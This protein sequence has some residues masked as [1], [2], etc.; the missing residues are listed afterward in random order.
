MSLNFLFE[1]MYKTC[2]FY[3]FK[4]KMICQNMCQKH[5]NILPCSNVYVNLF[6]NSYVKY[7]KD[8]LLSL[9]LQLIIGFN[10]F[11]FFL[12]EL[13]TRLSKLYFINEAQIQ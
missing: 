6:L 10:A 13:K 7:S 11:N 9:Q 1:N 3:T 8:Y 4:N 12:S 5:I 2:V